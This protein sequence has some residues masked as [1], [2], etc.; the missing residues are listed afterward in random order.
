MESI[1]PTATSADHS[2]ASIRT[3]RETSFCFMLKEWKT[4]TKL[5]EGQALAVITGQPAEREA[6]GVSL[7]KTLCPGGRVL[8]CAHTMASSLPPIIYEMYAHAHLQIVSPLLMFGTDWHWPCLDDSDFCRRK[9]EKKRNQSLTAQ[10][11]DKSQ[12]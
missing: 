7:L 4:K 1:H 2:K 6:R 9:E 12:A 10:H 11:D 5:Q 8:T 3:L